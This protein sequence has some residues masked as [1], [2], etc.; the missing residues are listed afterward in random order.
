VNPLQFAP[1]EDLESYPR[2]AAGDAAKAEAAG[3]DLLFMPSDEEMYPEPVR[4]TVAVDVAVGFMESRTRPT[5]F[6]GVATVVSKLF[7]LVGPCRA[8]FGEKDFQQLAV[9]RRLAF[10]L[11]FPVEVIGCP[12]VREPDG[13]A[14]SSRNAYL[15]P[16][17]RAAAPVLYRALTAGAARV[18]GGE[19]D[20]ASVREAMVAEIE[21][22]PLGELDYAEVV[23]AP[24]LEPA[25]DPLGGE[26]RLLVAVRFGAARLLDNLGVTT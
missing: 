20:P 17:E 5:H 11:S 8:Y 7:A 2:D 13:L 21:A 15:T 16:G 6:D 26:L 12:T 22:E 18:E 3:T 1:G 24:T 19:R 23:A 9:V 25:T 10:D 14:M 4:T